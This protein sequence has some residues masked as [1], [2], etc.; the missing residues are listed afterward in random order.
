[1]EEL[2][3]YVVGGYLPTSF[4]DWEGHVAPV[5]F[6]SGCN[7]RCPWCHNREV[8]LS[9]TDTIRVTD[10]LEDIKRRSKFLDGVVITGGEPTLWE[11][12]LP[13]LR[14][15]NEIG[16]AVK[17]D[18]NGS[19]P[20]LLE[21]ILDEKLVKRV[22]MDVKAPFDDAILERVTGVKIF[23]R[24]LRESVKIIKKLA[25]S[26]EFRTTWSLHILTEAELTRLQKDLDDDKNWVIQPFVPVDCLDHEYCR[27]PRVTAEEIKRILPNV[28]I[29]GQAT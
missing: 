4:L 14:E 19:N 26:Y 2:R 18:T 13:L 29:R 1:M 23:A 6:V 16:L 27:L 3:G 17:L 25:P 28:K 8:V 20:G 5:I 12:L 10:I 9:E 22:A 15:F 7:F 21:K 11:G 24:T